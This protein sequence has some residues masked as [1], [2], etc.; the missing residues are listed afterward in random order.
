MAR[1]ARN[2]HYLTFLRGYPGIPKKCDYGEFPQL[3]TITLII[4]TLATHID[5]WTGGVNGGKNPQ[6]LHGLRNH[7]RAPKVLANR[8]QLYAAR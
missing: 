3:I 4:D 5:V 2:T 8:I 7:L 6:F 1:F